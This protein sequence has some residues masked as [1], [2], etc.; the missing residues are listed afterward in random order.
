MKI[1]FKKIL[2]E[3]FAEEINA[4]FFRIN[5]LKIVFYEKL[6]FSKNSKK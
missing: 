2:I 4:K 3:N 1:W 6:S 5:F